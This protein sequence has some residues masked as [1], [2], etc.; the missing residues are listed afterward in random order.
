MGCYASQWQS[1]LKRVASVPQVAAK[2]LLPV[3]ANRTLA[4][5]VFAKEAYRKVTRCCRIA[6][7][8]TLQSPGAYDIAL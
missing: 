8:G 7:M 4:A 2:T 6:A 1:E 3:L 5:L